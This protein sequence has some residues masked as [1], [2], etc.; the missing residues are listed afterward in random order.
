MTHQLGTRIVFLADHPEHLP[1]VA[2]WFWDEWHRVQDGWSLEHVQNMIASEDCHR[3]KLNLTL[4]AIDHDNVCHGC[5]QLRADDFLEGY[6]HLGPWGASLYVNP[7]SRGV[8]GAVAY[9]LVYS[10]IRHAQRL[11]FERLYVYTP[12]LQKFLDRHHCTHFGTGHYAGKPV[13]VYYKD[14]MGDL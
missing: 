9:Q 3:D 10:L 6:R 14:L 7:E 2:H 1:K 5:V 12:S 4:I 8:S 13:D 11:G